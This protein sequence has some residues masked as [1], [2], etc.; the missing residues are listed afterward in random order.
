MGDDENNA[1]HDD[2]CEKENVDSVQDDD[3]DDDNG[4]DKEDDDDDVNGDG[5]RLDTE[6]FKTFGQKPIELME[7]DDTRGL[8]VVF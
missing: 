1:N 4:N 3:C 8:T 7:C 2:F 6:E 5:D